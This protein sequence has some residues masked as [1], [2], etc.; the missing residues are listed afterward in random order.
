MPEYLAPGVYVEEVSFR[1]KAIVGVPTSTC[2][3]VGPTL[4]GPKGTAPVLVTSFSD[5]VRKF[6]GLEDLSFSGVAQSLH[7]RNYMAH[8]AR[9]FFNNG[10]QRLYVARVLSGASAT[11]PLPDTAAYTAT[12]TRLDRLDDVSIVAAPGYS[13]FADLADGALSNAIQVALLAAVSGPARFRMAVLD[14]PPAVA[15]TKLR[16]LRAKV[17]SSQA[18]LYYPWVISQ[19]PL[20][21]TSPAQAAEISLPPSGFVC[22]I[23]AR[24]D[25]ER[26]VHKAPANELVAGALR[27]E[28][29]LSRSDQELLNP[30]GVNCLRTINNR[31]LRVWGAR[32]TSSDPEFKYLNV[33]RYLNYLGAS[34]SRGTRWS[35]FEPNGEGLWANVRDTISNFLHNE[36]R[37]GALLGSQ[38]Q[39]AWFVRCDRSTMTQNDL[40]LGQLVCL[41]GVAI[42]K[43][44][45][46]V[47]LRI[48][49]LTADAKPHGKTL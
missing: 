32:T 41:I 6:G 7:R 27:P 15:P 9:A 36:W 4:T 31:G 39:D 24:N 11:S 22:G 18:A 3:F 17:D 29:E 16:E 2:A 25:I 45:E 43:P 28:R 5:Y 21:G 37:N 13:A 23:Y 30:M 8:A 44:A 19:N 26:G 42:V 33:R 34:L 1:A 48:G 40:E 49:Q 14:A 47:T 46:F 38:A 12:F 10:G 20:A 35:V